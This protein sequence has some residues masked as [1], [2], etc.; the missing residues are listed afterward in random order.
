MFNEYMYYHHAK[1]D[2]YHNVRE[3]CNVKVFP[4]TENQLFQVS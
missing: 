4:Y 1:F 3:I 2:I